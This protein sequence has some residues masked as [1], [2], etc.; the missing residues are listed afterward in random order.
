MARPTRQPDGPIH[1]LLIQ[2]RFEASNFWN[3]TDAAATTGAKTVAP[4]LGLLTVAALLPQHWTFLLVDL[5][6]REVTDDEWQRADVICTGGMIPQ[7]NGIRELIRQANRDEKYIAVG[8]PD[9]TSQPEIYCDA[10]ARVLGEGELTIPMWLESWRAGEPCGLFSADNKPDVTCSPTPRF[11]LVDFS[12]YLQAGIQISRGCPFNCEFCDIIE[13]YG[14]IPRSKSPRQVLAELDRLVSLGYRG[15]VDISD[16]NFI[17][18]KKFVKTL[19]V[20]LED[21]CQ[22]NSFPFYFTTEA[23]MNLADDD[24]LLEMMRRVDF[25]FVFMGIET[26][27]PDLL[28]VTQKKVNSMKPIVERIHHVYRHGI[29]ISAGFILGFDNE[30]QGT[31]DAMIRCIEESGIMLAMVGLL[32]ALPNTQLTRRLMREGR[33]ISANHELLPPSD[34][35]YRLENIENA[36]NTTGGVNFVTTRD[37]IDVYDDYRRVVTAVYDPGQYM[38]RVMRTTRMLMPQRRQ[39]PTFAEWK[40]MT[41]ALIRIALWMTRN[42]DVRWHYWGNTIRSMFMGMARFEFCQSH[43]A[44][45]IHLGNQTSRVQSDMQTNID[46]ARNVATYPRSTKDLPQSNQPLLQITPVLCEPSLTK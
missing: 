13:L 33:M 15:W 18:N 19:L 5:N 3:L 45:F 11:D 20:E 4:P 7:Q 43:M 30:K 23:S 21:W 40:K 12:Q 25:R 41:I 16:D 36:D 6:V 44:A 46:F 2:P 1:C 34:G 9:P 24:E 28:A 35:A 8:G 26:P 39:K 22:R 42:R 31:A 38:R 29:S 14:R 10:D 32:S 17:G 37:R 27:D